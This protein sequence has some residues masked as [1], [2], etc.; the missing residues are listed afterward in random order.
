M[1]GGVNEVATNECVCALFCILRAKE[2]EHNSQKG[3]FQCALLSFSF[4]V[5][6]FLFAFVA[7]ALPSLSSSDPTSQPPKNHGWHHLETNKPILVV[8]HSLQLSLPHR[9]NHTPQ[10][11]PPPRLSCS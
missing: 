6:M 1:R 9:L 10:Q 4:F 8:I 7:P 3:T 5:S 2:K 11:S